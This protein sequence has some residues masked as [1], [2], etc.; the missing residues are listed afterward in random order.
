MSWFS[1]QDVGAKYAR[2]YSTK[3]RTVPPPI[4]AVIAAKHLGLWQAETDGQTTARTGVLLFIHCL[5]LTGHD[6]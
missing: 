6:E 5:L 4:L 3:K 1:C 2:S